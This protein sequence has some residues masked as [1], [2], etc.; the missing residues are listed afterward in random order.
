MMSVERLEFAVKKVVERVDAV[1][2]RGEE[3]T[4]QA[5][6]LPIIEALG[7]DI[8][9]P[10]EVCPEFEADTAI[11]KNGQKEKV[12]FALIKDGKPVIFIEC[13][14]FGEP[15]N[16]HEGQLARYFNSTPSVSLA[17]ITNGMEYRLFTDTGELNILD[18]DPFFI[19]N[20]NAVDRGIDILAKFAKPVFYAESI[21][22]YA[23]ELKYTAKIADF[24]SKELDIRNG[25]LTESLIR[26]ILSSEKMYDGRITANVVER[27]EPIAREALHRVIRKIVRRSVALIDEGVT[28]EDSPEADVEFKDQVAE[29]QLEQHTS[30]DKPD[31]SRR[32]IVTTEEELAG[33]NLVKAMFEK[34]P[35]AESTI[36]D[37]AARKDTSIEVQYKDTTA[38]FNIYLNKSSWWVLRLSLDSKSKWIG[39]DM[40]NE[41]I[42]EHLPESM[43]ILPS[44]SFAPVRVQIND[45]QDL[46]ALE[47][48]ILH[49]IQKQINQKD[50]MRSA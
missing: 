11:K 48:V 19:C 6:I 12:D 20:F 5:M 17:V 13:K 14:A 30:E 15:L 9:N 38:Y 22:E 2:G 24:L 31:N 4:K 47:G 49:S 27:F 41:E 21:R 35:F 32:Q 8:W 29:P 18:N 28:T 10:N 45:Y 33:F 42:L 7:Y 43:T 37:P 23:T 39:F 26:W 50:L 1:K 16:G 36:Y 44:T 34:S 40:T 25:I 3:A 46:S